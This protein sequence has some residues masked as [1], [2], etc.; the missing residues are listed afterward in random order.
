VREVLDDWVA[1][2]ASRN[3]E[4]L[5]G[6]YAP[7]LE[8][9]YGRRDV[10]SS[11]LRAELTRLYGRAERVEARVLGGP[12]VT[13]EDGGRTASARVRLSYSVEEKGGRTRRGEVTQQ[14]RLVKTG[15]GWKISNQRGEKMLR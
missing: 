7:E 2:A 12:Q 5:M 11:S 10:T 6:F 15:G 9:F 1:A 13:F 4:R 3:V 8:T 14:L